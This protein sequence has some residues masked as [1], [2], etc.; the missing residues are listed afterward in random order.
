MLDK[1]KYNYGGVVSF[2]FNGVSKIGIVVVIDLYGTFF[3][4]EEPSY[5]ILVK[6][7]D[8]LYKHIRESQLIG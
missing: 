4:K 3:Q 7:E 2:I 8:N 5:D 6:E 1:P